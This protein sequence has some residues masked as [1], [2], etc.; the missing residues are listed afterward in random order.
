[1]KERYEIFELEGEVVARDDDIP[2]DENKLK[3]NYILLLKA[4]ENLDIDIE[5]QKEEYEYRIA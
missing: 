1:M 4:F 2:N 5:I 3:D